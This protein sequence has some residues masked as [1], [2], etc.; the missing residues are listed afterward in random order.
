MP[1]KDRSPDLKYSLYLEVGSLIGEELDIE[2]SS[3]EVENTFNQY[4][5]LYTSYKN[6]SHLPSGAG[7]NKIPAPPKHSDALR[8]LDIVLKKRDQAS[9][10]SDNRFQLIPPKKRKNNTDEIAPFLKSAGQFLDNINSP[11]PLSTSLGLTQRKETCT[12]ASHCSSSSGF[13]GTDPD[14]SFFISVIHDFKKMTE[15]HQRELKCNVMFEIRKYL[16][17]YEENESLC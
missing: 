17:S 16:D 4:K 15:R 6:A 3:K 13:V 11:P 8:G 12:V 14:H 7:A 5:E 9:T 1:L 10:L 2:L